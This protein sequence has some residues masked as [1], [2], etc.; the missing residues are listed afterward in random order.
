MKLL[1]FNALIKKRNP[2]LITENKFTYDI[3]TKNMNS[4]TM[5][6]TNRSTLTAKTMWNDR[7]FKF[8]DQLLGR[9]DKWNLNLHGNSKLLSLTVCLFTRMRGYRAR[10]TEKI[11][12]RSAMEYLIE[13][14]KL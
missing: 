6:S 8:Y 5:N 12:S 10:G 4:I 3:Y 7:K 13:Y 11:R 9:H 14:F 2:H 1:D